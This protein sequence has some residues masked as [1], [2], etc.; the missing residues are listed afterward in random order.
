[1]KKNIQLRCSKA[2]YYYKLALFFPFSSSCFN[3]MDAGFTAQ[4]HRKPRVAACAKP[5]AS[6]RDTGGCIASLQPA[7]NCYTATRVPVG[8]AKGDNSIVIARGGNA[9]P[10]PRTAVGQRC[11]ASMALPCAS[12]C[13]PMIHNEFPSMVCWEEVQIVTVM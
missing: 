5:R 8:G 10:Q 13:L 7:F 4:S 3:K 11:P 6:R 2:L 1:M 12:G 9:S